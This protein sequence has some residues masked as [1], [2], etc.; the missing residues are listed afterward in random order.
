MNLTELFALNTNATHLG[1]VWRFGGCFDATA[2]DSFRSRHAQG[3]CCELAANPG[4]RQRDLYRAA[5]YRRKH[6]LSA[7][8]RAEVI[9]LELTGRLFSGLGD[10]GVF[11]TQ[12]SLHPVTGLP[13]IP[14]SAIKGVLRAWVK[15]R[16]R[17]LTAENSELAAQLPFLWLFGVSDGDAGS[18]GAEA[19]NAADAA[20]SAD[21]AAALIIHDAWWDPESQRAPLELE[22]DT[23]HHALYYTGAADA[24]SDT[25]DPN[26]NPQLAIAGR[27]LFAIDHAGIGA[28][29]AGVCMQWLQ[30]CLAEN[31]VGARTTLGYGRMVPVAANG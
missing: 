6:W 27:F 28:E 15:Q 23:P 2:A 24:A 21:S 19:A 22:V 18:A 20:E 30:A 29:W 1:L 4:P 3:V 17:L 8:G 16:H 10:K 13:R 14:G 7:P 25:D 12:A 9:S 31:G 5:F 26:P 11:E